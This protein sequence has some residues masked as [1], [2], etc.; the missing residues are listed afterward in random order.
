[1]LG[2]SG[3]AG[4]WAYLS[5]DTLLPDLKVSDLRHERLVDFEA[6]AALAASAGTSCTLLELAARAALLSFL[7][8]FLA[9]FL[10]SFLASFL[11]SFLASLMG[12]AA[13]DASMLGLT[14]SP[15]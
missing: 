3:L 14:Y 7:V 13:A 8:S 11:V 5:F 10:V 12:A 15:V 9:S 4:G 1:M 2:I 6:S